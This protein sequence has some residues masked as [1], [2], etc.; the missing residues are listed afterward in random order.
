MHN[1]GVFIGATL[2]DSG[3]S[4]EQE[5]EALPPW[6]PP[7]V[8]GE[9]RQME[10]GAERK[11]G[12]EGGEKMEECLCRN[13][14]RQRATQGSYCGQLCARPAPQLSGYFLK[15]AHYRVNRWLS[16]ICSG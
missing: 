6:G 7:L 13:E 11:R 10:G 16:S 8:G 3:Q 12:G 4:G 5:D 1:G 14:N 2:L 9:T 15:D